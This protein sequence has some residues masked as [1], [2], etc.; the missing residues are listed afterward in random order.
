[1]RLTSLSPTDWSGFSDG[2]RS[3]L[4]PF[5]PHGELPGDGFESIEGVTSRL[6]GDAGD[7]VPFEDRAVPV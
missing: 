2:F 4:D 6:D 1:M 5:K 3:T 7:V